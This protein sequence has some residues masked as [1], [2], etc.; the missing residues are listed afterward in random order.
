MTAH[1]VLNSGKG[2]HLSI[3]GEVQIHMVTMEMSVELSP[4]A[5][6]QSTTIPAMS[7]S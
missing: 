7:L 6:S 5:E 2:E 1:A 4:K 3:T